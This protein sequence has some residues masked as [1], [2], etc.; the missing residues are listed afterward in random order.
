MPCILSCNEEKMAANM[1]SMS[2]VN[3]N[4]CIHYFTEERQDLHSN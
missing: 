2:T 3:F 4:P 1:M